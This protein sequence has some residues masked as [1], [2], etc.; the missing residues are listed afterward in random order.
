MDLSKRF[1]TNNFEVRFQVRK[2][3][4]V[5]VTTRYSLWTDSFQN[6]VI[7]QGGHFYGTD[8]WNH[9][10]YFLTKPKLPPYSVWKFELGSKKWGNVTS[11]VDMRANFIR[12][13]G[14]AGVSVPHLNISFYIGFVLGY[15][16]G[17]MDVCT[18]GWNSGIHTPRSASTAPDLTIPQGGMMVFDHN[19]N[20]MTNESYGQPGMAYWH[21]SLNYLPIGKGKGFLIN[22]MGEMALAGVPRQDLPDISDEH[23]DPVR[24]SLTHSPSFFE[25]E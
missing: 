14:G 2:G 4:D 9:S 6:S 19:T 15:R 20:T 5:P 10:S 1:N 25:R 13:V 12:A 7:M 23:G 18:N 21:G 22:L 3:L 16:L 8:L 24:F 11:A 17:N